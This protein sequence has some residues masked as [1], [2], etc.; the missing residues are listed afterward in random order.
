MSLIEASRTGNIFRVRRLLRAGIDPNIVNNDGE[1]P[2]YWS[3][4]NG[5]LE[6]VRELLIAGADPDIANV[7]GGTPLRWAINNRHFEIIDEFENFFPSLRILSL[8][9]LRK[10]GVDVSSIP[11]NLL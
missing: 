8:I 7:Y 11:K 2:L 10:F 3:S 4:R 5:H 6:V 9:S 1:T